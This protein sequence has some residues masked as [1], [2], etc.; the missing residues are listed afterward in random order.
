MLSSK[1]DSVGLALFVTEAVDYHLNVISVCSIDDPDMMTD[2]TTVSGNGGGVGTC[3]LLV[4]L[5]N[6]TMVY[7]SERT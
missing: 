6:L 2:V 4:D 5:I 3:F 1:A 7:F